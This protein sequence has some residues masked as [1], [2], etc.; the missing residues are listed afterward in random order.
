MI[1]VLQME[2]R[3]QVLFCDESTPNI[4]SILGQCRRPAPLSHQRSFCPHNSNHSLRVRLIHR[5]SIP[6]RLVLFPGVSHLVKSITAAKYILT[7]LTALSLTWSP[8]LVTMSLDIYSHHLNHNK[9]H[10]AS[11][12]YQ[13]RLMKRD[14]MM[15]LHLV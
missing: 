10:N 12:N 4:F 6:R 1:V 9:H 5:L 7:T 15:I 11:V 14:L 13:V 2:P 3:L 8:W